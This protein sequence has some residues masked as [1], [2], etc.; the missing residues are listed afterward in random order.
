MKTWIKICAT[1]AAAALLASCKCPLCCEKKDA[2]ATGD[3]CAVSAP[4]QPKADA[5]APEAPAA[6]AKAPEAKP[7]A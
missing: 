2:A 7:A 1:V 3:A 4:A 6:D 5:K